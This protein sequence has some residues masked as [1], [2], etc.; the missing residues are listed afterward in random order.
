MKHLDSELNT[1]FFFSLLIYLFTL[2]MVSP[3]FFSC[4]KDPVMVVPECRY[5]HKPIFDSLK[6]LRH[7]WVYD[8]FNSISQE[9]AQFPDFELCITQSG[10]DQIIQ[11]FAFYPTPPSFL[12]LRT[13]KYLNNLAVSPKYL[14]Y[15]QIS[16]KLREL[17]FEA[18]DTLK[19]QPNFTALMQ[20]SNNTL[21]FK[22]WSNE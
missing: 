3:L 15:N 12:R 7:T 11:D 18:G 5:T 2:L 22:M 8:T 9:V 20:Y 17:H 6:L 19:L 1:S 10:C 14:V 16:K 21:H 13:I 4:S